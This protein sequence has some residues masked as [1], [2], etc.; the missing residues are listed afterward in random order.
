M[1]TRPYYRAYC[2]DCGCTVRSGDNSTFMD[3]FFLPERCPGCHRY[4][5]RHGYVSDSEARY[6]VEYG[7][8]KVVPIEPQPPRRW[9]WPFGVATERVWTVWQEVSS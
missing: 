2:K 4:A 7:F 9:W 5:P 6:R 1:M 3:Q 8:W